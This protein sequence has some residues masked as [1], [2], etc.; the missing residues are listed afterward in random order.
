ML[1]PPANPDAYKPVR[2]GLCKTISAFIEDCKK[3]TRTA[4]ELNR[5]HTD[6]VELL[7]WQKNTMQKTLDNFFI[8]SRYD[9]HDLQ[10]ARKA[11]AQTKKQL[12]AANAQLASLKEEN[13][14]Y[15]NLM[16]S[17]FVKLALRLRS[18]CR[19]LLGK[20]K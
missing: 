20:D 1:N 19:K 9:F 7:Q 13:R 11:L 5:L 10:D 17:R 14:N 8:E 6:P 18:I 2:E 16:N 4:T 12:D 15:R 3:E